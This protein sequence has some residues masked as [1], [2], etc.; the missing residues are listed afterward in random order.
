MSVF[1]V[2]V[3]KVEIL[4]ALLKLGEIKQNP[5]QGGYGGACLNSSSGE[6]VE[7]GIRSSRPPS[8]T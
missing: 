2:D 8:D 4:E 3:C 6:E 7:A 1:T 5:K